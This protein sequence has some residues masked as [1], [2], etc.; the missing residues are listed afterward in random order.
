MAL[1]K[2][3][4]TYQKERKLREIMS[5]FNCTYRKALT[6]YVAP[7][8]PR[9]RAREKIPTWNYMHVDK[10]TMSTFVE[11]KK[12]FSNGN[13]YV[14]GNLYSDVVKKTKSAEII[15]EEIANLNNSASIQN[16]KH[17][18]NKTHKIKDDDWY[19]PTYSESDSN[20]GEEKQSEEDRITLKELLVKLKNI[21]LSKRCTVQEKVKGTIKCCVEWLILVVVENIS[22]GDFIKNILDICLCSKANLN[23]KT[24]LNILQWNCRSLRSKLISLTN[25]LLQEKIHIAVLSETWLDVESIVKISNYN[26]F[27][28]DREDSYGGLA[29]LT[30]KSVQSYSLPIPQVSSTMQLLHIKISNCNQIENIIGVY[31]PP[32]ITTRQTDWDHI[33]SIG[34]R[35]AVILGDFNGHHTNWSLKNDSRGYQILEAL[36]DHNMVTLNDNRHTWLKL[37]NDVLHTSSPDISIASADIATFT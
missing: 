24:Q 20:I 4:P 9:S 10:T 37:I 16:V 32:N 6:M 11:T 23:K 2:M 26:I 28:C 25:L 14:Q 36:S 7:E 31:C 30:H 19:I 8:S 12:E 34:G 21:I 5:S 27:R 15:Q 1:S 3:C 13:D 18:R 17:N 29:I 33:F 22:E 35:R